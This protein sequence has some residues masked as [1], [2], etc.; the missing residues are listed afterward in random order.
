MSFNPCCSGFVV[1]TCKQMGVIG[2]LG[3]S[4]LVVVDSSLRPSH[5]IWICQSL[6]AS[7]L[8]VVDSSLR[9]RSHRCASPDLACFNP[10]C[11]GFVVKTHPANGFGIVTGCFNPCCS[12][13]VVKTWVG[14]PMANNLNMLQSLL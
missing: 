8:V 3:A 10:C 9:L 12:G 2:S 11:S 6:V 5:N 1:K 4:I 14:I 7:I 13:F